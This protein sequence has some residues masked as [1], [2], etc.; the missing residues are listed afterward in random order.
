[1]QDD[2][3]LDAIELRLKRNEVAGQQEERS[4]STH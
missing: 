3:R 1:M 2:E 4:L